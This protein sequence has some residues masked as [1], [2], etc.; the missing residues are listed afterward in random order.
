MRAM[1]GT[2]SAILVNY[3]GAQFLS[4]A[5]ESLARQTRKAEQ[6]IV[7]DNASSDGSAALVRARFPWVTL[8]EASTN[9]GFAEGNNIGLA[10]ATGDYV[11][12]LNTDAV[13]DARWLE[14]LVDA[15]ERDPHAAGAEGKIYYADART[16]IEQAGALFNNIGNYW[17]RGHRDEDRGQFEE[18]MEVAGVTACAMLV[19]RKALG[20]APLFDASLFMYGE[21]LDLTIRLRSD[22]WS[23]VFE[24]RAVVHHAG[25]R[26]LN[27][28]VDAPR[29]F[30]QFHANRNRLKLVAKYWPWPLL[31]RNLPLVALS[32]AYWDLVFL[33]R[34]GPRY[35]ARAVAAQ[36]AFFVRGLRE[37][38]AQHSY[39][40]LPWMTQHSF[41]GLKAQKRRMEG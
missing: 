16:R 17:G 6:V 31:L 8:I 20:G 37:R 27:A 41:R 4:D 29:L 28:A 30:Q 39:R 1:P 11:A 24:P 14:S 34:A 23:I 2:V 38:Q 3:N 9:T 13:A 5:L 40:W 26:S 22:G 19:R 21:E 25:M 32:I 33:V 12:L 7:V 15:L 10:A 36:I 18:S 35:F